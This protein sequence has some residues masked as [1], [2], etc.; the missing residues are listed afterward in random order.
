[1]AVLRRTRRLGSVR[2]WLDR[3][4][5]LYEVHCHDGGEVSTTGASGKPGKGGKPRTGKYVRG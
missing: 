4:T 1:M 5:D 3:R 2:P